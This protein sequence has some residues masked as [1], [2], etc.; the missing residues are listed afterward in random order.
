MQTFKIY[1]ENPY[2]EEFLDNTCHNVKI[3]EYRIASQTITVSKYVK[4]SS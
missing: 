1:H 2:C 3:P 4:V